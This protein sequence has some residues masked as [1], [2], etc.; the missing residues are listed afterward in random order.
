MSTAS[1]LA[2]SGKTVFASSFAIFATGQEKPFLLPPLQ[3]L[4]QGGLIIRL[5]ITF[6]I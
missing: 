6:V 1:G 4:Q 5:E 2:L 3:F